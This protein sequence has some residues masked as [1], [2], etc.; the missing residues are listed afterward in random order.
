MLIGHTMA[1]PEFNLVDA[2]SVFKI[3]GLEGIEIASMRP[4]EINIRFSSRPGGI[5]AIF[6]DPVWPGMTGDS[7]KG[8]RDVADRSDVPIITITP[9]VKAFNYYPDRAAADSAREELIR[10]VALAKELGA[11]YVRVYGGREV[12]DYAAG[13][14][15]AIESLKRI[16]SLAEQHGVTLLIENQP[17]TLTVTGTHPAR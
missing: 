14:D 10:Y 13:F 9:Y 3:I 4:D 6:R 17:G 5:P 8:L 11:R 1:V 2:F 16:A 7:K 15:L 12:D